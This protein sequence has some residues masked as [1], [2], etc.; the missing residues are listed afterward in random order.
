MFLMLLRGRV[1]KADKSQQEEKLV[2]YSLIGK[3]REWEERIEWVYCCRNTCLQ[4]V[5]WVLSECTE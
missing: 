3:L 2:F 5:A 1:L 4:T